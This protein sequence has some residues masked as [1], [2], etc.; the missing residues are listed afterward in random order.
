LKGRAA[1]VTIDLMAGAVDAEEA[2]RRLESLRRGAVEASGP[3]A[4]VLRV[5]EVNVARLQ[6]GRTDLEPYDSFVTPP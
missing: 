4:D 2:V 3:V 5:V 1:I 6:A